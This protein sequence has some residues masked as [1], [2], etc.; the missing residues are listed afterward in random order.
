[1]AWV[2]ALT[3]IF[4][5]V[6]SNLWSRACQC[7]LPRRSARANIG[8]ATNVGGVDGSQQM[9]EHCR[10]GRSD[11]RTASE[12]VFVHGMPVADADT[13][14]VH[15]QSALFGCRIGMR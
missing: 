7:Q 10:V 12:Y 14:D 9:W 2:W 6:N 8:R 15:G 11:D 5:D 4:D 3:I 13:M 1:M